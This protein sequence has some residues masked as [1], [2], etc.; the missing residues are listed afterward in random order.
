MSRPSISVS[1]FASGRWREIQVNAGIIARACSESHDCADVMPT[2]YHAAR[3]ANV[4]R[5]DKVV[6]IG[7]GAV[8]QCALSLQLHAWSFSGV[9]MARHV[10]QRW[11]WN[12]VPTAVVAEHWQRKREL[13][14]P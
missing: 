8:G 11:P 2:G 1:T 14:S 12:Q 10:A 3:V 6:V 4:Q 5:G 9:L 7:D 13:P